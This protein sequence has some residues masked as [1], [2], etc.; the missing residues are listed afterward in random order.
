MKGVCHHGDMATPRLQPT[1]EPETRER[2]IDAAVSVLAGEGPAEVKVRRISEEAGVSTITVYHHFGGVRGLLDEVVV[3]GYSML[4]Q[5]LLCAAACDD[6][7]GVQ[8]F[9][10]ALSTRAMAQDN[11]HLYDMM[12]GLSTRGTYRATPPTA[13]QHHFREAYSVL[14]GAC[15]RLV[16]SGR[17][18]VVDPDRLAGQLWSMVHG[19]VGLEAAGH[20]ADHDDAVTDVLA[21]LAVAQLVGNG[22]DR[23]RAT[24]C[25]ATAYRWWTSKSDSPG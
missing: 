5:A 23:A 14:L 8:L 16:S 21:P 25:A 13:P 2:L 17:L 1:R 4:R 24:D 9:A 10:M 12:F 3:R 18:D 6:D 7:P 22:D 15:E 19:F 11:P 20:F